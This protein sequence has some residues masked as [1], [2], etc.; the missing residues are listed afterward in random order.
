[1]SIGLLP[2]VFLL[3]GAAVWTMRRVR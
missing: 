3:V 1:V 2:G